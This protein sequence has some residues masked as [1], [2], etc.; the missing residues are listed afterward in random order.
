MYKSAQTRYLWFIRVNA[1]SFACLADAVL[2]LYAIKM[3][4]DDFLVSLIISFFYMTMPMMI[5]GKSAIARWGAIRTLSLGWTIR[6]LSGMLLFFIPL[7]QK[8][9][10]KS[11]GLF[12]FII[13]ALGFFAFRSFGVTGVTPTIR[14]ISSPENRGGF[15]SKTWLHSNLFLLIATSIIVLL[16]NNYASVN[17]FQ[18]IVLVGG[19]AGLAAAIIIY[20]LAESDGPKISAQIP[21][22]D[23]LRFIFQNRT[24]FRLLIVWSTTTAALMLVVPFSV[25]AIKIGYGVSDHQA[26]AFSLIQICGGIIASYANTLLLDRVGPRPMIIIYCFSKF[27]YPN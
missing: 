17:V 9:I 18:G 13:F 2:V 11:S 16:T 26:L 4:A 5:I 23:T 21:I 10:G 12:F 25:V 19:L 8:E 6:N 3:G 27:L 1:L 20:P 14:E 15:I 7:I 22:V 24:I